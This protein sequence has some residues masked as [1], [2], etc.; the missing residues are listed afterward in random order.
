MTGD[1]TTGWIASRRIG[2]AAGLIATSWAAAQVQVVAPAPQTMWH[3]VPLRSEISTLHLDGAEVEISG[4]QRW[5]W[6]CN[7]DLS[8]VTFDQLVS[9][10]TANMAR[11]EDP[12]SVIVDTGGARGSSI[13]IVFNTDASVPA[14]ALTALGLVEV[15]LEG[16]FGDPINVNV[17][18]D[19]ANL[20]GGVIG[21]TGSSYVTNVGWSTTRNGLQNDMDA[22]DTIQD[23]LPAGSTL[24]VR[25]DGGSATVTNENAINFTRANYRACIGTASG[26]VASMTFNST[27]NFDYDPSNGVGTRTSFVD[28]AVH[29]VG[30][31]LGF[32]SAAD[33]GAGQ[34]EALDIYRFQRTDGAGDYNPDTEAEF[35]T[36][37]RLID[38]NN[39][40]D[41]HNS[42]FGATT[43]RMSDGDPYQASHFREQSSNIGLMD[44]AIAAGETHYPDYFA[45]SDLTLFD[46]I[47]YDYPPCPIIFTQQPNAVETVCV[48]V[49]LQLTVATS[50]PSPTY[51]WRKGT[52]NLVNGGA[53]SGATT[54][55]LTIS[56]VGLSDA[57]TDYNC[58][59]TSGGCTRASNS[60]DVQVFD[61]APNFTAQP[62]SDTLAEGGIITLDV[63]VSSPFTYTY[64]WQKN[65]LDLAD[66]ARV[67]GSQS[68]NLTVDPAQLGD[69][70][71]FR[72]VVTSVFS[73]CQG[74]S[75]VATVTVT[76]PCSVN[77]TQQP[78]SQS[79]CTGSPVSLTVATDSPSP[80]Y[81]WRRG[82]TPLTNGGTISGATSP[83]LMISTAAAGDT[84]ANYN[85]MVTSGGACSAA[86]SNASITVDAPVNITSHPGA[87][88]VCQGNPGS[89]TVSTSAG[90][91]TF[92]WRRGT[93]PLVNG[94]AIS[95]ATSA[96]LSFSTIGVSDAGA[97]YNCV[98]T[99]GACT[100]I[101]NNGSIAVGVPP[102]FT[103]HPG[104]ETASEGDTVVL[105]VAVTNPANY[106]YLWHRNLIGLTDGARI[107]GSTTPTLTI[108]LAEVGDSGAY[109]CVATSIVG[110]CPGTSNAANVTVTAAPDCPGD[111]DGDGD[112]DV[113]DLSI[114][115][116][117]FGISSGANPED[118]D[119]DDDGDVDITDLSVQLGLF[120]TTC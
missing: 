60:C 106:T 24:P 59:I 48:G 31:A 85:C 109:D 57:A 111:L 113:T 1:V 72:C 90:S 53:I 42:D 110:A 117:N 83:T 35:Q 62:Q 101:S 120:G 93:T 105:S 119:L 56:A 95:G 71:S 16:L 118:G 116:S 43:Y 54:A 64:Q 94:G 11:F 86:S 36:R 55:T 67:N 30:H 39:P 81:Q 47:G 9:V 19:F 18:V 28:V 25:F 26:T 69:S 17:N 37:P 91:P 44:P 107:S 97:D 75:N 80:T 8:Q 7:T 33:G 21:A 79:V 4:E 112:V 34:T 63:T 68:A 77:F 102:S 65:G 88:T 70:G 76:P 45:T 14:N 82:T 87:L 115:L 15:Y 2:L 50:S 40:N 66:D 61:D 51:Q 13:N 23:W 78:Q 6:M 5:R 108:T 103:S 74:V 100:A 84:A 20:G 29:E 99:S 41:D 89:L 52:T 32:T 12:P 58:E 114:L 46:A 3:I 98:V 73:P 38:F 10:A 22:D 49:T 27:F 104:D 96:T 92:Q